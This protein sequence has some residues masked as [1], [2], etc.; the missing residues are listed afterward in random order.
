MP[1]QRRGSRQWRLVSAVVLAGSLGGFAL[2]QALGR[3]M[4]LRTPEA[5]S[6]TIQSQ[7]ELGVGIHPQTAATPTTHHPAAAPTG[8]QDGDRTYS[9]A[10]SN[11][12]SPAPP[13]ATPQA[14]PSPT[15]QPSPAAAAHGAGAAQ[16]Q[17]R[18]NHGKHGKA[19]GHNGKDDGAK[20]GKGHGHGPANA[21]HPKAPNPKPVRSGTAGSGSAGHQGHP[22]SGSSPYHAG[23]AKHEGSR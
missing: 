11:T 22:A 20:K 7:G 13:L 15:S 1:S 5:G 6:Q 9:P 3:Q 4:P 12:P 14:L 2:G 10:P 16:H 8:A 21:G 19:H 23:H 17:N 18:G